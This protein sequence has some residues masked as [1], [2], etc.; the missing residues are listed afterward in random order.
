M[1]KKPPINAKK[2]Q[3]KQK[4]TGQLL[5]FKSGLEA[6]CYRQ[7]TA[8]GF[9]VKYEPVRYILSDESVYNGDS[10]EI[11]GRGKKRGYRKV[12]NKVQKITYTPDFIGY[13]KYLD[14][15][16]II[17]TKGR[18]TPGFK[19]KWKLFKL[20]LNKTHKDNMPIL[21]KPTNN[22][23]IDITIKILKNEISTGSNKVPEKTGK[24]RKK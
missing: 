9:K 18:E 10:Y 11:F 7:L 3:I 4:S 22:K 20:Y 15:E 16:F 19:H 6:Y 14:K 13:S 12:P 24:R 21:F 2:T 17:E 23:E 5:S 8:H 1:K